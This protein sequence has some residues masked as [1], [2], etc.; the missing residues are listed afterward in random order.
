MTDKN[1]DF[2]EKWSRK[3]PSKQKNKNRETGIVRYCG[4]IQT[5]KFKTYR[6]FYF[7]K[8]HMTHFLFYGRRS[9]YLSSLSYG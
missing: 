3:T 5:L 1:H 2:L 7:E 6:K 4:M 9:L 8:T